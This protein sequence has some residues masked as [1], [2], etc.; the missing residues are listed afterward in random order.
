L[1]DDDESEQAPFMEMVLHQIEE[2]AAEKGV[3]VKSHV[4]KDVKNRANATVEYCNSVHADL[5][6]IMTDQDA[7]ISGFFLGPYSQQIIHLSKVPVIAI[8]PEELYD[9]NLSFLAGTSGN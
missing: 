7:E 1:L 4:L 5:V 2:M 3:L 6:I 9:T 8:R